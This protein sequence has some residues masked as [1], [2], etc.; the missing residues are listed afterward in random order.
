ME[1]MMQRNQSISSDGGEV[2]LPE[3]STVDA[4]SGK[5]TASIQF[6]DPTGFNA[7]LEPVCNRYG[8]LFIRGANVV[9]VRILP[10]SAFTTAT[11]VVN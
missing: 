6:E 10:T 8:Q 1:R 7:P 11:E 4:E 3:S 2:T 9:L 5:Q